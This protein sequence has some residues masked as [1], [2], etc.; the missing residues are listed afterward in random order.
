MFIFFMFIII[1]PSFALFCFYLYDKSGIK[2][3]SCS[4]NH[5][6]L[7]S[8]YI[9]ISTLFL[10]VMVSFLVI[11]VWNNYSSVSLNSQKE[12]QTIFLLYQ[13]IFSLPNT[14]KIQ[15][16]I[17][18]YLYY[19]INTEYPELKNNNVNQFGAE[20][21]GNLQYEIYNYSPNGN[22][23]DSIYSNCIS[24]LNDIVNLRT[25]RIHNGS[26]NYIIWVVAIFDSV[27]IVIMTWFLHCKQ[28]IH[29]VLIAF[30]SFFIAASLFL[31]FVLSYPFRGQNGLTSQPFQQALLAVEKYKNTIK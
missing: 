15:Q 27:L 21:L 10:A 12:A 13:N 16:I 22:R 9:S 26:L 18:K 8:I 31:I 23:E 29:Y 7:I 4:E 14:T 25:E 19:I 2:I 30:I 1:I 3:K 5:N 28:F 11:T 6:G 17:K 20:I 24:L